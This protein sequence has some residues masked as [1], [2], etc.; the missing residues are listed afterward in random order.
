MHILLSG[1]PPFCGRTD[2]EVISKIKTGVYSLKA[3]E[4]KNISKAGKILIR[5]MLIYDPEKRP[6]A[7]KCLEYDWFKKHEKIKGMGR[8]ITID[9]IN[10]LRSFCVSSNYKALVCSLSKSYNLLYS[11]S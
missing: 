10:N 7:L 11:T 1:Y 6:S 4:W 8:I 2:A 5:D 3:V 9:C